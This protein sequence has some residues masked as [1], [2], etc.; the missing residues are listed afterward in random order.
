M[1]RLATI[2][3][4]LIMLAAPAA[5]KIEKIAIPC[6]TGLCL[7]WWPKLPALKGWHHDQ[8]N[9]LYYAVNALAP[10]GFTCSNAETVM[11]A[12]ADYKPRMQE[13][14]S[15]DELIANDKKDFMANR[16]GVIISEVASLETGDGQKLRSLTFFPTGKGNWERVS[17][18]E[19]GDFFIVFTITSKSKAGYDKTV[20][21]YE[22]LVERYKENL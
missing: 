12:K 9:S 10:D 15:V 21:A 19:E 2:A 1:R 20:G 3:V 22:R 4:L 13:T 8:E 5:A 11:Y 7:Y 18:G 16:P 6:K 14:K 17:Y